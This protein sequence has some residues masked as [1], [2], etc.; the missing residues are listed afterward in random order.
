MHKYNKSC[1][2]LAWPLY[3]FLQLFEW[4]S[5]KTRKSVILV[6]KYHNSCSYL[7]LTVLRLIRTI[8]GKMSENSYFLQFSEQVSQIVFL[9]YLTVLLAYCNCMSRNLITLV[10]ARFQCRSITNRLLSLFYR[11]TADYNSMTWNVRN[12]VSPRYQCKCITKCFLRLFD[13]FT[14]YYNFMTWNIRKIIT[15]RFQCTSIT[16]RVLSLFDRFTA[17]YNYIT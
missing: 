2:Q 5:Q 6:H 7:N 12:L 4:K 15:P 16:N 14:A 10:S 17:S 8:L 13:R 9:A 1:S 11:F 3:H